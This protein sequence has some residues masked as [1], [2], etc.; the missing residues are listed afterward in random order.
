MRK[1]SIVGDLKYT[2]CGGVAQYAAQRGAIYTGFGSHVSRA[3]RCLAEDIRYAEFR[4][5][6]AAAS[7]RKSLDE[8]EKRIQ[9]TLVDWRVEQ[10][11]RFR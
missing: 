3:F 5:K 4:D 11:L 2:D 1:S 10:V 7:R 9:L 8:G 6:L